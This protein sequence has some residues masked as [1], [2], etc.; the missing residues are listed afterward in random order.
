MVKKNY[1]AIRKR[2]VTQVPSEAEAAKER[3][4]TLLVAQ[5]ALP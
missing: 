5:H 1:E 4:L 3:L 2:E